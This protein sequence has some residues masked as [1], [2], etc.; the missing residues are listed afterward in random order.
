MGID[1]ALERS[2]SGDGAHAWIF[3]AS[4][5]QASVTRQIGA[6]LL[7]EAMTV[8]AELDLASRRAPGEHRGWHQADTGRAAQDTEQETTGKGGERW[9]A[10]QELDAQTPPFS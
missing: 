1:A 10:R 4:P 6:H 7:R 2:R 3:F 8:R 5:V 9:R